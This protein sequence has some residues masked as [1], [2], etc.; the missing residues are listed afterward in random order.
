[1][2]GINLLFGSFKVWHGNKDEKIEFTSKRPLVP[3]EDMV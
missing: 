1:M 2:M 3:L